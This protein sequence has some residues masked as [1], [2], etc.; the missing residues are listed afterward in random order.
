LYSILVLTENGRESNYSPEHVEQTDASSFS[1]VSH[2]IVIIACCYFINTSTG[3]A[4]HGNIVASWV[5]RDHALN[6]SFHLLLETGCLQL[7]TILPLK[8]M[9]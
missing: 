3:F 8:H 4:I 1:F 6:P 9:T 7:G 5:N 2:I